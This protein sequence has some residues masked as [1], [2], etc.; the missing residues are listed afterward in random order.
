MVGY[1]AA[2]Q[3]AR[4]TP[5]CAAAGYTVTLPGWRVFMTDSCPTAPLLEG[6][7]DLGGSGMG[8]FTVLGIDTF[9]CGGSSQ[10]CLLGTGSSG[11]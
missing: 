1:A 5:R 7:G 3:A 4:N 8:W 9:S 2:E 6:G 11:P 10:R